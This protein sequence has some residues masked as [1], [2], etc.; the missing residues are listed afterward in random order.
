MPRLHPALAALALVLS[1][2]LSGAQTFDMP[3]AVPLDDVVCAPPAALVD[4]T[5]HPL[6]VVAAQDNMYRRVIDD[7]DLV[8]VSGGTSAGV[9]AGQR[10]FV[11]RAVRTPNYENANRHRPHPI[12]TSAVVRVV[13]AYDT[14]ALAQ[15]EHACGAIG[16]NDYLEPFT[17][18]PAVPR[19][20]SSETKSDLDFNRMGH[21]MFGDGER[22]LVRPGEW[23]L[24]DRGSGH[25]VTSGSRMAIYRDVHDPVPNVDQKRSPRLPLEAIGE[26]VVVS[27]GPSVAVV[28]VLS[29]G[30]AVRAGDFVVPRK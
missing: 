10:Y 15:V 11:R 21:V 25:G 4:K 24:I 6:R 9:A 18:P 30:D 28:E 20:E 27:I 12:H 2:C 23:M 29:A 19:P 1:P 16:A 22:T 17:P 3:G 7:R 8:V 26:A 14:S 13:T 5:P